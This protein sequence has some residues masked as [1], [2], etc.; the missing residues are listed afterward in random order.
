MT[1]LPT[2]AERTPRAARPAGFE[3]RFFCTQTKT[4]CDPAPLSSNP[5][6]QPAPPV[7]LQSSLSRHLLPTGPRHAEP[8]PPWPSTL[9]RAG[10]PSARPQGRTERGVPIG[11]DQWPSLKRANPP[12]GRTWPDDSRMGHARVIPNPPIPQILLCSSN[13]RGASSASAIDEPQATQPRLVP[14]A[15][16]VAVYRRMI[17]SCIASWIRVHFAEPRRA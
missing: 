16:T 14:N 3:P 5:L 2:T 11:T 13:P 4:T 1:A 12:R 15:A 17:S 7:R 6:A 8:A 9:H 10:P